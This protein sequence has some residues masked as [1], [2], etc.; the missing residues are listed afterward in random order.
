VL[1]AAAILFGGYRA[2]RGAAQARVLQVD[3]ILMQGNERISNG[4][5]LAMLSGLR[6]QNLLRVDLESWRH[7]LLSSPWVRDVHLRRS[8]PS[9]IEV[10]IA[11]RQPVGIGRIKGQLYLVDGRGVIIDEYGPQYSDLDLP[12]IDGLP[13]AGESGTTDAARIDLAARVVAAVKANPDIA[14]RLSQIDVRDIHNAAVILTGDSEL[15]HLGDQQF[16]ARLQSYVE[17]AP[18]LRAKV[19]GID[20]VDLRFDGRVYVKPTGKSTKGGSSAR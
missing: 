2:V 14:R 11:E 8:L 19:A 7:R 10:V 5:V 6:G 9:T 17:L 3:R 4:E 18:T 1:I 13:E 12:I 20:L 15:I 16:L